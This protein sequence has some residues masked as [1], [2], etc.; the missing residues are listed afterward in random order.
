MRISLKLDEKL[1][2]QAVRLGGHKTKAQAVHAALV[3]YVGSRNRL[4]ILDLEGQIEFDPEWDYKKMR[5]KR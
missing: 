3:E 1:L 2:A 4:S 5:G